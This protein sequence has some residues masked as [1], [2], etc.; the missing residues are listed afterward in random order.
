MKSRPGATVYVAHAEVSYLC[1]FECVWKEEKVGVVLPS[2]QLY[3]FCFECV[4]YELYVV[5]KVHQYF[6]DVL[7][8]LGG[9][10]QWRCVLSAERDNSGPLTGYPCNW[11]VFS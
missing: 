11:G 10:T 7:M 9:V 6:G 4:V 3:P 1:T 5:D 2:L 8:S